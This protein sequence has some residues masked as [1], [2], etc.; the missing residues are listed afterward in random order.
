MP[1]PDNPIRTLLDPK[2]PFIELSRESATRVP[3]AGLRKWVPV[4]GFA[5]ISG[6]NIGFGV[7]TYIA[8]FK[9]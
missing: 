2:I 4:S 1:V 6:G 3:L 5:V 7:T 9:S 8:C